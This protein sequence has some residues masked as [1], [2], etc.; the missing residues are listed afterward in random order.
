MV[1]V[2][3][4]SLVLYLILLLVLIR[5]WRKLFVK[6]DTTHEKPLL[7]VII[8]FRNE[9]AVIGDLLRDLTKQDYP[10]FEILLVDD[11]SVDN[12]VAIARAVI[13][14]HPQFRI[15]TNAGEGKK[16]ALS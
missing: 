7:S 8:P 2:L 5:G 6:K 9:E 3:S 4:A 12:T 16:K 14:N 15:I 13:L 1:Y 10:G 11:H